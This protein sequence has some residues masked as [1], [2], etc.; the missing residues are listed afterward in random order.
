MSTPVVMKPIRET[1]PRLKARIAGALYLLAVL[2]AGAFE[3][4]IRGRLLFL[5]SLIPI[6][7]FVAVTLLLYG[8][9]K[10]VSTSLSLLAALLSLAGLT[11][12]AFEWQPQNV[13]VALVFHGFYCLLIGYLTVGSSF[14]PRILGALMAFGGLGWLTFLSPPLADHLSPYHVVCGFLGEGSFMLWLLAV[15]VNAERW[16]EQ[17]ISR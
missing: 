12:E 9:F 15:G 8:I 14:L 5:V 16:K 1:S 11:F 6:S 13:N 10:Q 3:A 7:C 2:T 4:S 17:A